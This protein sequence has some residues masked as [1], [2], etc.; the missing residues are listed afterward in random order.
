MIQNAD[1]MAIL[2][3]I[4]PYFHNFFFSFVDELKC[5]NLINLL[6]YVS[7]E[8][9]KKLFG[10]PFEKRTWKLIGVT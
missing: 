6:L 8:V 10:G 7:D 3:C 5:I 9:E 2:L 1:S 4:Q